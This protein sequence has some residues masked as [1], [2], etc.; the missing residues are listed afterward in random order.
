[1]KEKMLYAF[2]FLII[3]SIMVSCSKKSRLVELGDYTGLTYTEHTEKHLEMPT[4]EHIAK[5]IQDE[6]EITM[7]KYIEVTDRDTVEAGDTITI[8]YDSYIAGEL[9]GT[10]NIDML[11]VGKN[12]YLPVLE[13]QLPGKKIGTEYEITVIMPDD[14]ILS[15]AAGKEVTFKIIINSIGYWDIPEMTDDYIHSKGY[16]SYDE[17]FQD[18]MECNIYDRIFWK[19]RLTGIDIIEQ[20]AQNSKFIL[21]D[22]EVE[23]QYNKRIEEEKRAAKTYELPMKNYISSILKQTE[24]EFE[25]SCRYDAELVIK[26]KLIEAEI[27]ELEGI[28]IPDSDLDRIAKERYISSKALADGREDVRQFLIQQKLYE[29]LVSNSSPAK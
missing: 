23:E 21:N 3:G 29:F 24:T 4:E 11:C 7:G 22:D 14:Y 16:D 13:E 5:V 1:M 17:M 2:L 19:N 27:I 10:V 28:D 25:K 26:R 12:T 6:F 9:F 15:D 8:S 20:I 18:V